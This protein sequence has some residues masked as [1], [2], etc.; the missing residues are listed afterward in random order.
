MRKEI[1]NIGFLGFGTVGSGAVRIL[2]ENNVEISSRLSPRLKVKTICSPNIAKRDTSWVR[3]EVK[4]T[5]DP[6]VVLNDP[7][8]DIVVEAIGG[9]EP[10][11]SYINQAFEQN[12]N[13]VTAN[14]LLLAQEGINLAKLAASKKLSLAIEASVAG[15]IPI[16]NA[17]REG[18]AAEKIVS[19]YGILNGTTNFILTEMEKSGAAFDITLAQAQRLGYAEADPTLDI[20]GL[21]A[22]DKLAILSMFCFG[23]YTS[24]EEIPTQGI[25]QLTPID[26]VYAN[27]AR[28][29][30]K[31]LCMAKIVDNDLLLSVAPTMVPHNSLLAKVNGSFNAI[32][33]TGASG[34]QTF[35]YGRGAGSGPT[36]IAVV[37]DIIRIARELTNGHTS[38]SSTFSFQNL[39]KSNVTELSQPYSFSV[40]F[41]VNNHL[42]VVAKLASI[43][44]ENNINIH[45]ISQDK[46]LT[47]KT[48]L[49]FVTMLEP[50]TPQQLHKALEEIKKLDFLIQTPLA[51]RIEENI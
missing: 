40:R 10:A 2:Q 22:R 45:S 50:T 39:E 34:G 23:R 18:I 32:M 41:T 29:T 27:Q 37:S 15:G 21:D 5:T 8:I 42:G 47:D 7:E 3:D 13:V 49:S 48:N 6:N 14:K 17:I 28:C 11:L 43:L 31:L 36:G 9:R 4:Y 20:E 30:I 33:I 51:M 25:T 35:Y 46:L 38:L 26:F 24:L 1:V 16:L 19:L 44:S 12:K